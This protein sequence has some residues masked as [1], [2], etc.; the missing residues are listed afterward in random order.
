M[1]QTVALFHSFVGVA[2][3]LTCIAEYMH[4]QP[5]IAAGTADMPNFIK[6]MAFVG[7]FIGGITATG[8]LVA[9]GKLNGSIFGKSVSSAARPP[10]GG[11]V[12]NLALL[13]GSFAPLYPMMA[14]NS[15]SLEQGVQY[16]M[17]PTVG[18]AILGVT[19][20]DAV[21]GADMPVI[22]TVLNSYSGWALAAEGFL[23]NNNMLVGVGSLIGTSFKYYYY[24]CR[25]KIIAEI[26]FGCT[27]KFATAIINPLYY[28]FYNE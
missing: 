13:A 11:Q 26:I 24:Y 20:T 25:D 27:R 18:S 5:A 8:S 22:I 28:Y 19:L 4:M 2:A 12:T 17:A 23:L 21:G 10:P 3:S 7:T 14:D 15:I 6:A 9:F 16:M 1:P